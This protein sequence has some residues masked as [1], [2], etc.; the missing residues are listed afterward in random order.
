MKTITL[1]IFFFKMGLKE[2]QKEDRINVINIER[3]AKNTYILHLTINTRTDIFP[4]G[5]LDDLTMPTSG[6]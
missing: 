4:P 3:Y 1:R 5:I 6:N 2:K